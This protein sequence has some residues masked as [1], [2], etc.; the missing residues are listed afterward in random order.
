MLEELR[1]HWPPEGQILLLKAALADL[2]TARQAWRQWQ[3]GPD[4]ADASWGE[5]CLLAA[6]ARRMPELAGDAPPDPRL[7][8]A[9]RHIWTRTQLTYASTRPLL[10]TLR[11]EGLR[12]MLIKG[13]ARLSA[14]P[15][16]AQDRALRDVDVLIHPDDWERSIALANREGW[17]AVNRDLIV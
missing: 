5:V 8:G 13:A 3:A 6:L 1:R 9:R 15:T 11:A 14:D 7:L 4:L 16:L 2:E 10:A 17:A 12:M